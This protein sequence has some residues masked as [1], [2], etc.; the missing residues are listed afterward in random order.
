MKFS[1]ILLL[2]AQSLLAQQDLNQKA[3]KDQTP[4]QREKELV[5]IVDLKDNVY[6]GAQIN[7]CFKI[8][9]EDLN[10]IYVSGKNRLK[11]FSSEDC[12]DGDIYEIQSNFVVNGN[13]DGWNSGIIVEASK[14]TNGIPSGRRHLRAGQQDLTK[15]YWPNE[16]ME[17]REKEVV[18]LLDYYDNLYYGAQINTC[19][20]FPKERIDSIVVGGKNILKVFSSD[21]CSNGE[22][23]EIKG[24]YSVDEDSDNWLSGKVIEPHNSNTTPSGRRYLK[25]AGNH[26]RGRGSSSRRHLRASSD[27]RRSRR[28]G[29]YQNYRVY[30]D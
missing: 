6:D 16:I 11:V 17:N 24:T 14:N 13:N 25:A 15:E 2:A 10:T 29:K 4:E 21:D 1:T 22:L 28:S 26:H 23:T 5:T 19:F 8:P 9:K 3:W 20:K 12:T 7:K 30:R 18:S 27:H